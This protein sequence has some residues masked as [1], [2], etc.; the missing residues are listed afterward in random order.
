[1]RSIATAHDAPRDDYR[2]CKLIGIANREEF[3]PAG[4]LLLTCEVCRLDCACHAKRDI[5]DR[6]SPT[7]HRPLLTFSQYEP[8]APQPPPHFP[9]LQSFSF[10]VPSH[11]SPLSA[12]RALYI[13][14]SIFAL[15]SFAQIGNWKLE[16]GN[17]EFDLRHYF[18][19]PYSQF[20]IRFGVNR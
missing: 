11:F 13:R 3:R 17:R 1:M 5:A 15:R 20:R 18:H 2:L 12:L 14:S 4:R 6:H 10:F 7:I 8:P 19:I 16:I 9:T